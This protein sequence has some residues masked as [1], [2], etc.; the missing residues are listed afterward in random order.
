MIEEYRTRTLFL[1][2]TESMFRDLKNMN[3]DIDSTMRQALLNEIER[4]NEFQ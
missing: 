2:I 3:I 1:V 4:K